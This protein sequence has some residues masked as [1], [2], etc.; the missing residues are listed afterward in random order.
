LKAAS[1]RAPRKVLLVLLKRDGAILDM[2]W[3]KF[4]YVPA[5]GSGCKQKLD[6]E[7]RHCS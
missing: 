5:M 3:P 7:A 6:G 4:D 2:L 1:P